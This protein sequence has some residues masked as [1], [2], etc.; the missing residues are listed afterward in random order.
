MKIVSL[1]TFTRPE[2]SIVKVTTENGSK[3][4]GQ[5]STY[6]AD[7]SAEVFHRQ[8]APHALGKDPANIEKIIS[9][10]L[11]AEYK[12][13]GTYMCRALSGLDT[14]L[15]DL[16]GKLAGK[17]VCELLGGTIG[18]VDVYGSSM[19]RD[20]NPEDEAKRLKKLKNKFGFK[21]F[22]IRI[23]KICGHDEDQW[24][25]RTEKIVPAVREAI[26]DDTMLYVDANSCYTPE[27]AIEV[28]QMLERYNVV[29]FEEPCPYW[30]IDWTRQVTDTLDIPV[31]AGEQ[32]KTLEQGKRIINNQVLDIVQPDIC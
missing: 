27:K 11:E 1:E 24:P 32:D 18:E 30:K 7:I 16:K 4:Y 31:A 21:A 20:I 15:W 10:C 2:V 26:G 12:F 8:V 23:G 25:G 13:P 19:R 5:I 28:G 17:S 22:K 14:S 29:H 6:N 3:G 9:N